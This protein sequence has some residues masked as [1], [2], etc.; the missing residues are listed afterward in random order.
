VRGLDDLDG[1][2]GFAIVEGEVAAL[3]QMAGDGEAHLAPGGIRFQVG[4][5]LGVADVTVGV[6]A[7][8]R[9]RGRIDARD[10]ASGGEPKIRVSHW[11]QVEAVG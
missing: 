2:P 4:E 8:V 3:G 1:A 10:V 11:A 6:G 7:R 5:R 9:V